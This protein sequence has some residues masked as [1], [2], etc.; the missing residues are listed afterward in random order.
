[1]KIENYQFGKIKINDKTYTNDLIVFK[2]KIKDNWWRKEGHLLQVKDL[3]SVFEKSPKLLI[4]GTG[5]SGRMKVSDEVK[6]KLKQKEIEFKILKTKKACKV[7]NKT[8]HSAAALH[9]TC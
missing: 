5:A 2:D 4:I 8:N 9:L 3:D 6:E 1:M 7:F